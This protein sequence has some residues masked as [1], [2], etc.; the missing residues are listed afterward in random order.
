MKFELANYLVRIVSYL[1]RKGI[2]QNKN[3]ISVLKERAII[4]SANYIEKNLGN[5]L[6]FISREELWRYAS[7][8]CISEGLNLEFGVHKGDSIR[9]F[10]RLPQF[11]HTTI[12]GF[13]S[14]EG[15]KENW[16]GTRAIAGHFDQKGRAPYAPKNVVFVKGWF[17]ETLPNFLSDNKEMLRFL[18]LDADTYPSTKIVLN[19]LNGRFDTGTIVVFDEYYGYI[20]WQNGEFKA[21]MEF[22][23]E[24]KI[25][26]EYI[27]FGAQQTAI[28]II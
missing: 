28:R 16:P 22:S 15:L 12:F 2:V 25:N 18:H 5:A 9:F 27:A 1:Y 8:S 26:Y 7:S 19:L 11:K 4:S 13:D 21:W 14:F 20:N 24:N 10:S 3:P 17:D 23:S 6:V